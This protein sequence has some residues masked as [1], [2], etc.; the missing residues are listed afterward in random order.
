MSALNVTIEN[1]EKEVL[2]STKTVLL[3]FFASWCGPCRMLSPIVD[4]LANEH[5]ELV[6][7]KI[8]IDEQPLLAAKYD[9]M[10]V[11]TL[12]VF[13]NGTITNQSVGAIPKHQ[14]LELL[15]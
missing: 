8:N 10:S 3:D 12:I 6:V 1:F 4:E 2:Q 7:G 5:P 11:P 9:V 14:I 13:K 15:K